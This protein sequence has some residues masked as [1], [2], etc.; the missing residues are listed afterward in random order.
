[1]P[2]GIIASTLPT[3]ATTPVA[4]CSEIALSVPTITAMSVAD[5]AVVSE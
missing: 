5:A 1:M 4:R 2:S 3:T